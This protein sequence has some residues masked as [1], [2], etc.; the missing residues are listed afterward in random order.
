M[1]TDLRA[2]AHDL[3]RTG[4]GILAID[5]SSGTCNARFAKLGIEQTHEQRRA[6]RELLI[7]APGIGE[8]VSGMI[9]YDETIRQSTQSGVRF[10]DALRARGIAVGIKVDSGTTLLPHTADET[11][12]E[13][14]DGLRKRLAEYRTMGASFAK[15]R[16]VFRIAR[17]TPSARAIRANAHALARYAALCQESGF[18]PIVEPE[19]LAE[20]DHPLER[21]ADVTRAVLRAV[22]SELEEHGVALEGIVLKPSMVLAGFA[23]ARQPALGETVAATLGVLR[24]TVPAAVPGIAFLSGGQDDRAATQLLG[25]LNVASPDAPWALTFSYGRAIQR[26][27]LEHWRGNPH[28][29][30]EAQRILLQRA[31]QNALA[32]RGAYDP[33]NEERLLVGAAS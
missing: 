30:G 31:Y 5:E 22:F 2:V 18:V 20:G 27:A 33:G 6:Y 19:L 24:E 4:A 13:G 32:A 9:L 17:D 8:F 7:T 12:T 3:V 28:A 11:I 15:W 26:P 1:Q 16:A 23:N 14:L 21:C 25:A 10:V 29:V